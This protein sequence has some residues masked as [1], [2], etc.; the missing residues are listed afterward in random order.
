MFKSNI[1]NR[2]SDVYK[3]HLTC[4]I[5][6]LKKQNII[7]DIV[8]NFN[9]IEMLF[10]RIVMGS[11]I[12][13]VYEIDNINDITLINRVG[14]LDF[15]VDEFNVDQIKRYNVKHQKQ[16]YTRFSDS[17]WHFRSYKKLLL[18]L[19]L[20][21]GFDNSKRLLDVDDSLPVLEH[22]VG[23]V[24]VKNIE[25]DNNGNPVLN[26]KIINLLF[27]DFSKIKEMLENKDNDLYKYFPRIFNEWEMIKLNEKDKSLKV[28]LDYLK[29]DDVS[30][31]PKYYRLEGL[32]KDIGCGN[33]IV[34]ETLLL[35]D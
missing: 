34:S 23:N 2:S 14:R 18:K 13:I 10:Y 35:H 27:S 6:Y 33:N 11:S 32:F 9:E 28:I 8:N 30:L 25:L 4:F 29:S 15:K 31:P 20:L 5:L 3:K 16:F 21:I 1:I 12:T 24:D 7:L 22:L 26:S 17:D 19:M